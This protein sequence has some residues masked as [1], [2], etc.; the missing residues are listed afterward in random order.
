MP[1]SASSAADQLSVQQLRTF[2]RVYEMQGYSAAA[3]E[4]QLS[5]PAA[6]EQ[7]RGLQERYGTELFQ[8]RGR[9]IMPTQA[10]DELYRALQPVLAGLD[11]TFDLLREET[12]A[13]RQPLTIVAGARM[14]LED[15]GPALR[16]FQTEFPAIQLRILDRDNRTAQELI[17]SGAADLAFS[18]QPGPGYLHDAVEMQTAYRVDY[19]AVVHKRHP[20]ARKPRWKLKD[21]VGQPLLI[22]HA[23]THVRQLFEQALHRG[24][25]H[26]PLTIVAETDNSAFT[27]ACVKAGMG[28]GILAGNPAGALCRRLAVRSLGDELGEARIV[29]QWK[30]GR[31]LPRAMQRLIETIQGSHG[32]SAT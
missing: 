5:V 1:L 12:L 32:P 4:L 30:R 20:L 3:D 17:A 14:M 28:V 31:Q 29:C 23:G 18:L 2:C 19:L 22:G 7:V 24:S 13:P 15:L 25:L 27:L 11:S 10:G 8:R 21:I 6:W 26:G 9:R 16:T